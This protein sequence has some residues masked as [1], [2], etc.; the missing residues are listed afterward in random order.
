MAS[1]YEY[2]TVAIL[3]AFARK[4]YSAIDANYTDAV[5][6][7]QITAAEEIVNSVCGQSFTGTI[8]DGVKIATKI[9]ARE[10]MLNILYE[11]GWLTEITYNKNY[12]DDQIDKALAVHHYSPVDSI[13]MNGIDRY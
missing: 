7:A 12:Y 8:P 2:I 4:D 1:T 6:E 5:I 11:D 13:A 3:E 9:I 10:L